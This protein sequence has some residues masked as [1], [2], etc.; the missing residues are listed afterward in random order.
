MGESYDISKQMLAFNGRLP[1]ATEPFE[2]ERYSIVYFTHSSMLRDNGDLFTKLRKLGFNVL[3]Q[4]VHQT[5]SAD[6]LAAPLWNTSEVADQED[7]EEILPEL[8]AS[9]QSSCCDCSASDWSDDPTDYDSEEESYDETSYLAWH[10]D[11]KAASS[12]GPR[13]TE[14]EEE[15][16]EA[17][18]RA[19]QWSGEAQR[20]CG[21]L[22]TSE[23]GDSVPLI[24]GLSLRD[25][26]LLYARDI[27]SSTLQHKQ[28]NDFQSCASLSYH[29][30][31]RGD[32]D[33]EDVCEIFGGAGG[34][35]H[36]AVR[37]KLEGSMNFDITCGI[38]LTNA[39]EV[40]ALFDYLK[41]SKVFCVIMD[42]PCTAFGPW[43][44]VN[45]AKFR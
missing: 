13:G 26:L 5:A 32:I 38:D 29:L 14:D 35:L 33:Y 45:R 8:D 19:E 12:M 4:G 42:P 28:E 37:R 9:S 3:A 20:S 40:I 44:Q 16:A 34:V 17:S 10:D 24:E 18:V 6:K 30:R 27:P 23:W 1:H 15:E 43:I 2:G 36:M 11:N 21:S 39:K 7:K 25:T 41:N 31:H 22:I